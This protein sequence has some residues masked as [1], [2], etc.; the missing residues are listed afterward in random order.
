MA[1]YT[2][3]EKPFLEKL[4]QAHWQVIDQGQGILVD[5]TKS[6]RTSFGEVA[7][8]GEFIAIPIL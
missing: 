7:L 5:P 1:E 6:L 3:V 2:D 4:G 8:N